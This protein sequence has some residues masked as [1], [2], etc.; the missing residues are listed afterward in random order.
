MGGGQ[1]ASC[2]LTALAWRDGAALRVRWH[3]AV[4]GNE[5]DLHNAHWHGN[6]VVRG[7]AHQDQFSLF[8]GSTVSA[9]MIADNP[10]VWLL[11]CHVGPCFLANATIC[12]PLPDAASRP[13]PSMLAKACAPAFA[14]CSRVAGCPACCE[15]A[16]NVGPV[17]ALQRGPSGQMSECFPG[18][19]TAEGQACAA[20]V[21][22]FLSAFAIGRVA[23]Q[24]VAPADLFQ[25]AFTGV[26]ER[27]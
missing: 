26:L 22:C 1:H 6:V 27:W 24:P 13:G 3:V 17:G 5:V 20:C 2:C 10:G 23:A 7:G 21:P 12:L 15:K 14:A 25:Q 4:E 16:T 9:D 8:P 18:R 19:G 11:H